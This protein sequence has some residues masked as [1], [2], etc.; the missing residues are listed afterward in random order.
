MW[1]IEYSNAQPRPLYPI[2][3]EYAKELY[4]EYKEIP[5]ER[6]FRLEAV[7]DFILQNKSYHRLSEIIFIGTNQSTRSQMAQAWAYAAAYYYGLDDVKFFSGGLKP[8]RISENTIEALERAGFI[9]YRI[10]EGGQ[11]YYQVKYSFKVNPI[12][13]YP[14]EVDDRNNPPSEFMAVM[15]CPNAAQN[16][17]VVKGTYNRL[18]L[19]YY[20]P[21]GYDGL[22][23][24]KEEYDKICHQIALEMFYLFSRLKNA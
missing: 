18:E 2:L 6:R 20:D 23:E 21:S 15:V 14:K 10:K 24:E 3:H 12:L 17:S 16:L 5:E 9:V 1:G 7:A 11:N 19:T 22:E 13:L 8:E 4:P